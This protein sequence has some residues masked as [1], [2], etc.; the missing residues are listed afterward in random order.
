[1]KPTPCLKGACEWAFNTNAYS[2]NLI[3]DPVTSS[4]QAAGT[5]GAQ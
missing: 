2:S 3:C 1:M 4:A 5:N